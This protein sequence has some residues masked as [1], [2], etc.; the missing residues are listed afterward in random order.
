MYNLSS[1][2]DRQRF[3]RILEVRVSEW[4]HSLVMSFKAL[5]SNF[6]SR[7][8]RKEST[9]SHH[10]HDHDAPGQLELREAD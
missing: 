5:R 8:K 9:E 4:F 2:D 7:R 6:C 3:D 1:A 10:D